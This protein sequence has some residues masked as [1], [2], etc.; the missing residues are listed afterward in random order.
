MKLAL[1]LDLYR[2]ARLEVPIDRICRVE[3]L[4]YHSVWTA[5]A[6]GADALSP[7]AYIAALTERI[8]LGTAVVQVAARTPAATAMHAMTIDAL[9]GGECARLVLGQAALDELVRD[10]V[11]EVAP[12]RGDLERG[13]GGQQIQEPIAVAGGLSA[14]DDVSRA[15]RGPAVPSMRLRRLSRP[16]RMWVLTVPRG[17]PVVLAI[18]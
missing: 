13:D 4:G 18:S 9:A 16:R 17:R 6:Y 14:H 2:G 5:E 15:G 7:L 1:G 11:R 12:D 3:A 8:R 10:V